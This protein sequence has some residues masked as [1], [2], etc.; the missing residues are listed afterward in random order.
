ML[1]W[2]TVPGGGVQRLG[3]RYASSSWNP[4]SKAANG[5]TKADMYEVPEESQ[6]MEDY[7]TQIQ[8]LES[9]VREEYIEARRNKSRLS[10]SHRQILK[11]EAPYEGT[12]FQYTDLHRSRK[13]R[14]KMLGRYGVKSGIDPGT[15]WPTKRDIDLAREYEALYQ[16]EPLSKQIADTIRAEEAVKEKRIEIEA[17]ID[18]N[19]ERLESQ[20]KALKVR[21]EN[22][23]RLALGEKT[24]REKILA[25][26][27]T[28]FGYDVNPEDEIMKGRIADREKVLL[29]E[30]REIKKQLKK[31]RDAERR[32]AAA[33]ETDN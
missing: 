27:R 14:A 13:F 23:S 6:E 26:L 2:L 33:A 11:G 25:E 1:K 5:G 16:P 32:A 22:K 12:V 24:R 7:Q 28:E 17:K 4:F 29:K 20:M 21:T 3:I 18:A 19:L 15:L 30:E 8:N 10:A 9:E 31:E